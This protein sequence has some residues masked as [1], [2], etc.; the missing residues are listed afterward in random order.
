MSLSKLRHPKRK[1]WTSES[2]AAVVKSVQDGMGVRELAS[3]LYNVPFETLTRR[4]THTVSLECCPGPPTVLID[5]E[6]HKLTL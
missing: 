1:V 3:R 5:K 2:M 4:T 6:E